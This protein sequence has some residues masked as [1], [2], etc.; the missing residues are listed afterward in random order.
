[1]MSHL[2]IIDSL[3][4]CL[5]LFSLIVVLLNCCRKKYREL[6]L[7]IIWLLCLN[8][9]YYGAM[10][11]EW[12]NITHELDRFED[13]AGAL[14]PMGWAFVLYF[15]IHYITI[16]DLRESENEFRTLFESANDGLQ[17][18][19]HEK[20]VNCNNTAAALFG[21][22][23]KT[24]IGRSPLE[25]SPEFQPDGESSKLK[26]ERFINAALAG[27]PQ[28]FYWQTVRKDG[29]TVDMEV[30]LN[31]VAFKNKAYLLSMERDITLKLKAE[32]ALRE[33]E[34]RLSLLMK[35]LQGM[36]Y[37]CDKDWKFKFVSGGA[38]NLT[39]YSPEEITVG[40][41]ISHPDL[42]FE[43][44]RDNVLARLRE[45]LGKHRLFSVEYRLKTR[46][47]EEKW[48]AEK[49]MGIFA[50]NGELT[51]IEGFLND[52][53][54]LKKAE[55]ELRRNNE[56]LETKVQMRT[57]ELRA[58]KEQAESANKA[59]SM[60]LS[61]MSHE[62]RTP[63]NAILGFSQLMRRD[64]DLNSTQAKYLN[65]INR[66]GEHLL[67]LIN[68]VLEM[69][70]IEAGYIVLQPEPLD[71]RRLIDDLFNMFKVRCDAK[72]LQFDLAL[73][74]DV[75]RFIK[76]DAPKLR[77]AV[78]NMLS[79]ALKFTAKGG[80]VL[81]VSKAPEQDVKNKVKLY[82]EVE[83]TG[84]GISR[85]DIEAVFTPFE[86]ADSEHWHEGTGLGM[87]IS[88][89]FARMMDGD[90]TVESKPGKG[91]NFI[92][93]F[94]TEIVSGA[95][96]K[97]KFDVNK[98]SVS[99][100]AP[101]QKEYNILVADDDDTNLELLLEL[102]KS[103]GF[104]TC[105]ARDGEEA[106]EV[107]R[108]EKPDAI[109]MD[110]HMPKADG[111]MAT[112]RIKT[113]PE[114]KNVPVII[115]TAS[116]LNQNRAAA[117]QAGADAFIKKPYIEDDLLGELKELLNLKY[118]YYPEEDES[119]TV[120][121][122]NTDMTAEIKKLPETLVAQMREAVATGDL[123]K[124]LSLIDSGG[125]APGPAVYLRTRAENFEYEN[126]EKLLSGK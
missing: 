2:A 102:L 124:L 91:S 53:T 10:L 47:G 42:I 37:R 84:C 19:D 49:G 60:F 59:K 111:F 66:S 41:A 39:G 5:T 97:K 21:Y 57:A 6:Y 115:V 82:I 48:V 11:L 107:F 109:L 27:K 118:E 14:I 31:K 40:N 86:Q 26:S 98:S 33:S 45:A 95:D 13:I 79:N 51:G 89:Q 55:H 75:P 20:F 93:T 71:L 106:V 1:M 117:L 96:I 54:K 18:M 52:I 9:L 74:D 81:R 105:S 99:G 56:V 76:G 77:E 30:S 29:S 62:I 22:D 92:F 25:F 58:A 112:R 64:S 83:D 125:M 23:K 80:I 16:R 7:Q 87:P 35:N 46:N 121:P 50:E 69:S 110:Y 65:T 28:R 88:R 114:G 108:K 113:L 17:L 101:N 36:A 8:L 43:D 67:A 90:L 103:V 15:F 4:V 120:S 116:A 34:R 122:P 104:K 70:K 123:N 100:L 24:I 12:M 32:S 119:P 73:E 85:E 68:N 38:L 63:M 126:L 3:T 78:M 44:D 61:K 94:R 72:G